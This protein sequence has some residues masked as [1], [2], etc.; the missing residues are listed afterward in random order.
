MISTAK[1]ECHQVKI[2]R[3]AA[4]KAKMRG[5]VRSLLRLPFYSLGVRLALDTTAT[6]TTIDS[7]LLYFSDYELKESKGD[8]DLRLQ[9]S[10]FRV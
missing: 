7:N 3:K 10:L 8:T 9:T 2:S 6:H 1:T 5:T 4:K